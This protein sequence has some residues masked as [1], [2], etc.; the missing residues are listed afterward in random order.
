[1]AIFASVPRYTHNHAASKSIAHCSGFTFGNATEYMHRL[2][3]CALLGGA[4]GS[5]QRCFSD[6]M[7]AQFVLLM[8]TCEGQRSVCCDVVSVCYMRQ[9]AAN[10]GQVRRAHRR[11]CSCAVW[12][13][14]SVCIAACGLRNLYAFQRLDTAPSNPI[15]SVCLQVVNRRRCDASSP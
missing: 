10:A 9:A 7:H 5:R 8:S 4:A 11:S 13:A 12:P 15:P 6:C 2:R 14:Q 1:M 3:Q